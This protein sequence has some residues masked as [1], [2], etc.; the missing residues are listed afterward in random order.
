MYQSALT[1]LHDGQCIIMPRGLFSASSAKMQ[2]ANS[3]LPL[4]QCILEAQGQSAVLLCVAIRL[5][6]CCALSIAH[7]CR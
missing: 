4:L 7:R 2:I 5:L 6:Q 3:T 1:Q